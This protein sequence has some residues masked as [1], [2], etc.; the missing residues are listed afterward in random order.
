MHPVLL[1]T[2]SES[3]QVLSQAVAFGDSTLLR[4]PVLSSFI[5]GGMY[6]RCEALGTYNGHN[7]ISCEKLDVASGCRLGWAKSENM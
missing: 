6:R 4:C 2:T 7:K 3:N 5:V 1:G